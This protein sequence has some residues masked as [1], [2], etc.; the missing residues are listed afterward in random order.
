MTSKACSN[1]SH[2]LEKPRE[3][4]ANTSDAEHRKLYAASKEAI[5]IRPADPQ[6]RTADV[7]L[8]SQPL[9][10]WVW[11]AAAASPCGSNYGHR[12]FLSDQRGAGDLPIWR[13]RARDSCWYKTLAKVQSGTAVKMLEELAKLLAASEKHAEITSSRDHFVECGVPDASKASWNRR[14]PKYTVGG[15]SSVTTASVKKGVAQV[16]FDKK[17]KTIAWARENGDDAPASQNTCRPKR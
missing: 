12:C 11:H 14:H 3:A 6:R 7:H 13:S 5:A 15:R 17:R 9:S 2:I 8:P 10:P 4:C 16:R 1:C